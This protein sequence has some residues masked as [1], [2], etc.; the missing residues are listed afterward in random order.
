MTLLPEV[1]SF[2]RKF[3]CQ[4]W[5]G[6]LNCWPVSLSEAPKIIQGVANA[7]GCLQNCKGRPHC[8]THHTLWIQGPENQ[9]GTK[10]EASILL[11]SSYSTRRNSQTPGTKVINSR[12]QL[13]ILCAA[14][15]TF[16]R[17][18]PT[19]PVVARLLQYSQVLFDWIW[20]PLHWERIYT[21]YWVYC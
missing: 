9:A 7:L 1:N 10:L 5:S 6:S 2:N 18:L 20:G 13:L 12:S 8:G 16:W 21:F 11:A 17:G 4:E 3:Q 19:G 14:V 15:P